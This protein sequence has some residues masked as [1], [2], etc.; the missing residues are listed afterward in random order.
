M[1]THVSGS[2]SLRKLHSLLAFTGIIFWALLFSGCVAQKADLARV[3]KDL[4]KQIT[5]LNQDK[6]ELETIIAKNREDAESL[7]TQQG[8][9][10]KDLFRARAEIRQELKALREAD[11]TTLTGDIE[12]IDFRLKKIRQDLDAQSS[13]TDTRLQSL[14]IEIDEQGTS[15]DTKL[16]ATDAKLIATQEQLTAL[17]QQIDEDSQTRNK[18]FS[19]FQTSLSAFKESM[20]GLGN[21]IIQETERANQ[22]DTELS[23]EFNQKI[24]GLNATIASLDTKLGSLETE[25][26]TQNTN[27]QEV[28]ASVGQIRG[29]LDESGALVGGQVTN[30]ESSLSQLETHVNSLTEKLNADTQALRGYLEQDVKTS[31]NSMTDNLQ[32]QLEEVDAQTQNNITYIQELTQSVRALKEKQEFVGGLLGE[33]GD[34]FMQESGRLNERLNSLETYQDN[35]TQKM[36]ANT[37]STANHLTEVNASLSS[38]TQAL[39]NTSGALATRLDQQEQQLNSLTTSLQSIQEVKDDFESVL[40]TLQANS[41]TSNEM[42]TALQRMNTRLQELELH[43]SGLVGKLDADGQAM[44]NHLAE[45]NTGIQSVATALQ[46]VDEKLR[47]KIDAQD[48]KLNQALTTVQSIQGSDETAKANLTHLNQLTQTI[49][50]LRDVVDTIGTKLGGRVDQHESRLAELAKRVNLLSSRSKRKK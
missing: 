6:A 39:E 17:I 44:N 43:Q 41:Q 7:Q 3:Q 5:Q 24:D 36:E 42:Q 21:Q 1:T 8:A 50:Q 25:V 2:R 14:E 31:I 9:A 18:Q 35:L 32:G 28:S 47:S 49:N 20:S 40:P 16:T 12:E 33:R 22:A 4:E 10:M 38:V 27:L 29:A 30:L 13:Q 45:V 15:L 37:Q 19:E 11:L 48:R 34:K 26:Q 46:Q 23:N